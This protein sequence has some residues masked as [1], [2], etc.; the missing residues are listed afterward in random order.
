MTVQT[1]ELNQGLERTRDPGLAGRVAV[2]AYGAVAYA[3]F[4][5]A[6]L[7][8]VGFVGNWV[9]PKSIDSGRPGALVPSLLINGG[10]LSLFVIQHT[11]MA[12]PAF[13]RAW[14]RVIPRAAERSTFVLLASSI[15]LLIFWQWRPLPQVVWEVRAPLP[16]AALTGISLLGYGIVLAASFMVSHLD[17]FGLRQSWLEFRGRLYRPVGFRLVGL[18]R[19]VRH[20]LMLGFLIAFWAAPLMTVG[21]LFFAIMT[22]GY[23]VMGIWFEERDLVA[24]HGESYR[25]Y[26]RTTRAVRPLPRRAS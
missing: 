16:A 21:H 17:L 22:T 1:T 23:I 26:R 20:P 25:R 6:F 10:L 12:R 9:V 11:V 24:A 19:L 4:L 8:A 18:Y 5:V 15:L 7:Y 13:K 14:T 2:L 3:A